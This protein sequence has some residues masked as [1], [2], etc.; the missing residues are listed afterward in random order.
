VSAALAA[1]T[2]GSGF[3]GSAVVDALVRAG[4]RV[5]V[6]DRREPHRDDVEWVDVDILEQSALR[7][8]LAGAG[9]VF[10]LAAMADVNDVISDPVRATAVNV[11]GTVNAL[12]AARQAGTGRFVLASTVWVYG[13]T[14][15]ERVDETTHFDP[16]T[17]RHL[18]VS[19]KI[20]AELACRD[21]LT[22]YK[23]PFTVLRYGIPYGPRMRD[24]TVL[25]S[26]FRRALSG[27]P[28]RIDGDG[29]Q[30]RNFIYV[31]DLARA[32]VLA[33]R[34]EAENLVINVD[35]PEPVTI[36]QLAELTS[37]LV[38]GVPVEFGP[39]RPGDLAARVV[40]SERAREVLGWEP[41]VGIDEGVRRTYAWYVTERL[42]EPAR[43]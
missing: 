32:H 31:E 25:S 26:F 15:G 23:R 24:T 43:G 38:G 42:G 27:E 34:P 2:G 21:Y 19:T 9:P 7:D 40:V 37:E 33:L 6:L 12:E 35:G 39:P 4:H 3:I 18:Y 11:L 41:E 13:A 14:R 22:L 1:V 28:L 30:A 17:D 36:R 8:A 10:H 20:A 16:D 5:R 29:R